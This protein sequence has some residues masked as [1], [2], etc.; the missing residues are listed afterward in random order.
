MPDN[1]E[2]ALKA[3]TRAYY[4]FHRKKNL[5]AKRAYER[6]YYAKNREKMRE[7]QRAHYANNPEFRQANQ[8]RTDAWVKENREARLAHQKRY[9]EKNRDKLH[10]AHHE[11]IRDGSGGMSAAYKERSQRKLIQR[12]AD[13]ETMA[14]RPRPE[15][16]EVC[17]GPPDS[18]KGMHFD[19]CHKHGHFRGWICR[20][21]N[22]ILGY[23]KDDRY[24]LLKLIAYLDRSQDGITDQH[25]LP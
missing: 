17:G 22:L 20:G 15:V 24:R 6:A 13:L 2:E 11:Y 23:A 9:R 1:D 25:N 5:E 4:N 10:K 8:A 14:G 3:I 19:H 12:A 18:K 7:R 21:C 16:C